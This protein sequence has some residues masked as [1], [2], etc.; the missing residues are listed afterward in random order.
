VDNFIVCYTMDMKHT[1]I[2]LPMLQHAVLLWVCTKEEAEEMYKN[3]EYSDIEQ[4]M[5]FDGHGKTIFTRGL[6]AIMWIDST[7]DKQL[8]YS[9]L[10]HECVHATNVILSDRGVVINEYNDEIRA[11]M[12]QYLMEY[13]IKWGVGKKGGESKAR[14]KK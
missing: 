6:K 7:L 5:E 9:I 11:Y 8:T 2:P 10:A 3:T 12:V 1:E 4:N 13:A 14:K